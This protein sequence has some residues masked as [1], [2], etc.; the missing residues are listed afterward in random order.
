[1]AADKVNKRLPQGKAETDGAPTAA[2]P[3]QGY[4][5]IGEFPMAP[6][7]TACETLCRL[8]GYRRA[9]SEDLYFAP[10][11]RPRVRIPDD[12]AEV[13]AVL[14]NAVP[15]PKPGE[16]PMPEA[17]Q[18]VMKLWRAGRL[19]PGHVKDGEFQ[20]LPDEINQYAVVIA[21]D[22]R[23]RPD[24]RAAL[25]DQ[26]PAW[27]WWT[28]NEAAP[29]PD[30]HIGDISFRTLEIRECSALDGNFDAS[31]SRVDTLRPEGVPIAPQRPTHL[32]TPEEYD[33]CIEALHKE[34][35]LGAPP[36]T[37]DY[38]WE[39]APAWLLRHCNAE[40]RYKAMRPQFYSKR[41]ADKRR[42]RGK[43]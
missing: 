13:S 32:A 22:G 9:I 12:S 15:D 2:L 30:K 40:A 27:H 24:A 19:H 3:A 28:A 10:L 21:V 20:E 26:Q 5:A 1:M 37:F 8:S 41:H 34:R 7:M 16:D 25:R 38:V 36:L 11:R 18:R 39:R 6:Y 23:I 35:Q 29:P 43:P 4:P 17:E 31:P 14:H 42:R 33:A